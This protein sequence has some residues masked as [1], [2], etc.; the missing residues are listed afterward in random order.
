M[1][2]IRAIGERIKLGAMIAAGLVSMGGFAEQAHARGT[3]TVQCHD[4]QGN[5]KWE[6]EFPNLVTTVG[7]ND[8]L[9][10]YCAGSSYTAALYIGLISSTSYTA[11]ALA[12]TMA[13]HAGWL[14]AGGTNAP[15]YTQGARPT[16]AWAAAASKSKALSSPLT[17]TIGATGGT[18]KG[19]FLTT[20]A[21]KD[22]TTGVLVSAGLFTGGDKV[23]AT[24]DTLSVSYSLGV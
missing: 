21:T 12:D 14:E 18:I 13:S 17:Y 1:K 2:K 16:T 11:V 15:L 3:Y 4:E 24:G 9:D 6:D 23:V 19:C 22:G 10:K 20:V 8:M 7:G 5:L